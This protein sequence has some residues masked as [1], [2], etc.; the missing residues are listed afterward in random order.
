MGQSSC[1]SINSIKML[2]ITATIKHMTTASH[3][4]QTSNHSTHDNSTYDN[5]SH[6]NCTYINFTY[7]NFTYTGKEIGNRRKKVLF[8][9]VLCMSNRG[10]KN[11]SYKYINSQTTTTIKHIV[12]L[13][14]SP[15]IWCFIWFRIGIVRRASRRNNGYKLS[16]LVGLDKASLNY[17]GKY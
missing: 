5:R 6:T 15:K 14:T 10:K 4:H 8:L 9:H 17:I 12:C 11:S 3:K 13:L 7:T 2:P 16:T 1:Y